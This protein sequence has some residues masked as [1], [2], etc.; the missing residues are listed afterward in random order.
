MT[1]VK[2]ENLYYLGPDG[3]NAQSAMFKAVDLCKINAVNKIPKKA[4]KAVLN[5]VEQDISSFCVLPI[6]NS[7]E[8]IVRETIDNLFK[9]FFLINCTKIVINRV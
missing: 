4:I 5:S 7:I 8:G 6:E 3:S 2:V 9:I 1:E